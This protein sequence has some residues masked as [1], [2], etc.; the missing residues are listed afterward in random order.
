MVV[1]LQELNP[2]SKT[3][4]YLRQLSDRNNNIAETVYFHYVQ[5]CANLQKEMIFV[6]KTK[7][8]P[9]KQKLYINYIKVYFHS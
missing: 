4:Q 8:T 1:F 2:P 6:K 5:K 9:K 7:K 3:P